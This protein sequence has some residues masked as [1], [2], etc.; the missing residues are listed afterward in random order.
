MSAPH[1][2]EDD[3]VA[4][5][6]DEGDDALRA[7]AASCAGCARRV[8]DA[9]ATLRAGERAL[10][11]LARVEALP[12]E[13]VE[14]ALARLH[15]S[16]GGVSRPWLAPLLCAVA[17]AVLL[18]RWIAA[19]T[20]WVS[21]V[22]AG[23]ALATARL[24]LTRHARLAALLATLCALALATFGDA[25]AGVLRLATG[26]GCIGLELL[27]GLGVGAAT[28][29]FALARRDAASVTAACAAGALAAQ[30]A[31]TLSC[32]GAG[33]HAHTLLFHALG[34]ALAALA[35]P[36]VARLTPTPY[37]ARSEPAS[38]S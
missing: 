1:L 36:L 5:A 29:R 30:S 15:A 11:P 25:P 22:T 27:V 26:T 17:A 13:A 19:P 33:G 6:F 20:L 14:L 18:R 10:A 35:G 23:V 34:V 4:L 7:H 21:L 8:R 9:R 38:T 12:P 16:L 3:C 2:T 24:A 28:A 37:A 31:V 32:H